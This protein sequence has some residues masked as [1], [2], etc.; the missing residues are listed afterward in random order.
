VLRIFPDSH[1]AVAALAARVA[2][3]AGSAIAARG[4]F[5]LGVSGGETPVALYRLLASEAW[6]D[7]IEWR[8]V[9]V[10]FADERAVPVGAPERNDRLV[11]ETLARPLGLSEVQLCSMRGEAADLDAAARAYER[12]VAAPV[13]LLLLGVGPDGHVASL[14][15][16]RA[17]VGERN[18]RVMA[19][20]DSPKP[21]P[22]RLTLTPRAIDEARVVCVLTVGD[23][24]ASAV[25][26]AL[27][28]GADAGECPAALVAARDWYVDR[29]AAAARTTAR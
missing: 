16:G 24:K 21:P 13:D 3:E 15:P 29:A 12:E 9:V 14:F 28:P 6:R 2:S 19:V 1:A 17:A 11:R 25:A 26:K 23:A 8:R 22:G 5:R 7:R 18:R 10:L 4:A 20:L 27:A